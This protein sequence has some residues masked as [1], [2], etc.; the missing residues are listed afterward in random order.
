MTTCHFSFV[1][2]LL[3]KRYAYNTTQDITCIIKCCMHF[4]F[5]CVVLRKRKKKT[6]RV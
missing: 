3:Y 2:K 1:I 5:W 6:S 4:W